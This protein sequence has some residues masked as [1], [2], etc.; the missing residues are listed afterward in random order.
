M[1]PQKPI[2]KAQNKITVTTE[3][4]VRPLLCSL[5]R[6]PAPAFVATNSVPDGNGSRADEKRV[7][8]NTVETLR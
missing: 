4:P 1:K 3:L 7:T 8:G 5:Q 2:M 6:D